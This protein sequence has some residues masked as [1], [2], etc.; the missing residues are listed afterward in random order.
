MDNTKYLYT[1]TI[2]DKDNLE[3]YVMFQPHSAIETNK[4]LDKLEFFINNACLNNRF[5]LCLNKEVPNA[6]AF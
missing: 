2:N 6:E 4:E 5:E 1:I 3:S